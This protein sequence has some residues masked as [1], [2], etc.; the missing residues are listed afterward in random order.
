MFQTGLEQRRLMKLGP[1]DKPDVSADTHGSPQPLWRGSSGRVRREPKG[2]SEA[3]GGGRLRG[4]GWTGCLR[5]SPRHP[6]AATEEPRQK[7]MRQQ[8]HTMVST[9]INK[10][11]QLK[12][13]YERTNKNN[14]NFRKQNKSGR[15][16]WR[17]LKLKVETSCSLR[18]EP[19]ADVCKHLQTSPDLQLMFENISRRL[20]TI[21]WCL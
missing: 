9:E 4:R 8:K 10:N 2:L 21:S 12:T 6:S 15:R 3:T 16:R 17:E 7:K 5:R 14:E 18:G 13:K 11:K 1:E 20:Q 19:S